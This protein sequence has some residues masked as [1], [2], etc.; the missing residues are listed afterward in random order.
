MSQIKPRYYQF[1]SYIIGIIF[2]LSIGST[3]YA[4]PPTAQPVALPNDQ[5][6][7]NLK[8]ANKTFDQLNLK[9][10]V[11]NLNIEH[12]DTAIATLNDLINDAKSCISLNQKKLSSLDNLLKETSEHTKE[13][14]KNSV[15]TEQVKNTEK[16]SADLVYVK[17]EQKNISDKLAQC[18]LFSIRAQEAINTYQIAISKI[19]QKQVLTRG[20][21]VWTLWDRLQKEVSQ[22]TINFP[23]Q[24]GIVSFI[25]PIFTQLCIIA[26]L[27]G[28]LSI[29]TIRNLK[30][31]AITQYLLR[32]K[33]IGFYDSLL[34]FISLLVT[35]L[36]L[37][38]INTLSIPNDLNTVIGDLVIMGCVYF[39]TL[40]AINTIFKSK[41]VS[42][43]FFWYSLDG[44]FFRNVLIFLLS[45]YTI[46]K[47]GGSVIQ[48]LPVN[49]VTWQLSQIVFITGVVITAIGFVY[50]FCHT[51]R[52]IQ[53][54]RA[55]HKLLQRA[56]ALL[57]ISCGIIN[58]F[59]YHQMAIHLIYASI[60]TFAILFSVFLLTYAVQKLY[61]LCAY[62]S[63]I[64][65]TIIRTLGYKANQT[66]IEFIIL[67]ITLQTIVCAYGLYF[68]GQTWGYGAYYLN[69]AYVQVF[70]GIHFANFTFYPNRI[71]AGLIVFCVLYL[72]F[73]SVSTKFSR[74]TQFE[75]EEETQ[76][77]IASILTYI[78]FTC[79]LVAAL[80]ISGIDFT[81]LAIVAGA[82]SVGIGL[83]LQSIVNNFVSGIILL[84]EKPIKPGDHINIDGIEGIVKKIRIRS[85]QI[86]TSARED[87]IIPNSDLI[88][89]SV[90][91][92]MYTDRYL[93]IACEVGVAYDSDPELVKKLLA[94]AV[95]EHD[96]IIKSP[97]AKSTVLF[98]KFGSSAMI[99]QIWFLIKDGNKKAIVRSDVN[100]KIDRL[101][102]EH[103]I[104][105]AHP[106]RDINIKLSE[107]PTELTDK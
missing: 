37:Y 73:R 12:L 13:I 46:S 41:I 39:W 67:K 8:Q 66:V 51:H 104:Q 90:T 69:T 30:S 22:T 63:P 77:A 70:K 17:Q 101:F 5:P 32:V 40:V 97:R 9:L 81:G 59:G 4:A 6:E 26:M 56:I 94:Q 88:T 57:F 106:Q 48:T 107:I 65:R 49:S 100:F 36:S 18:R 11:E 44:H 98:H 54:I 62:P 92:Y 95:S 34:L 75:E 80:L 68:I 15:A 7:F 31:H 28:I 93:S 50:Y 87:V 72:F 20:L 33:H 102:R 35:C 43:I 78:G 47:I 55:H 76:V 74:R 89:R 3:L 23:S 105:I 79:A 64:Y 27:C 83:G 61:L 25:Q 19:K 38:F 1:F 53:F 16:T 84:L 42:A 24:S 58:I 103:G 29:I 91:N 96:E 52:H 45:Y 21:P 14:E 71:V 2:I 86:T 60:T 82:L 10:S 85:T 99:F